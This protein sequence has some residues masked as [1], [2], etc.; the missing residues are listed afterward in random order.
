LV[1]LI[2]V[3]YSKKAPSFA[4]IDDIE[5]KFKDHY[6]KIYTDAK[7]YNIEVL[8]EEKKLEMYG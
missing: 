2:K 4:P 3:Q 1:P 8:D 7:S 6:G 5:A